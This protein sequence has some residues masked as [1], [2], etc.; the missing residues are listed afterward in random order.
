M[1]DWEWAEERIAEL[2]NGRRQ[3]R[4][5]ADGRATRKHDVISERYLVE[6]KS[7]GSKSMRLPWDYLEGVRARA[8]KLGLEPIIA[9][10][11]LGNNP[12]PILR[13]DINLLRDEPINDGARTLCIRRE[14]RGRNWT[15][16]W[17]WR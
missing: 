13:A 15:V 17:A 7:T 1:K 10:V 5:G 11:F 4:S 14:T 12:C 9:A 8:T 6:V 3:H 2:V 16:N